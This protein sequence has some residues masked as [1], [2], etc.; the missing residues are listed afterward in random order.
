MSRSFPIAGCRRHS[1]TD[2][3]SR[4]ERRSR[5]DSMASW[6]S[7]FERTGVRSLVS[8]YQPWLFL[9]GPH[10]HRRR[11]LGAGDAVAERVHQPILQI[12]N[13]LGGL[14]LRRPLVTGERN[15]ADAF[16]PNP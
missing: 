4:L 13:L 6:T 1:A 15:E 11:R 2:P 9:S 3:D 5:P 16:G 8:V 7:R 12:D 10:R 14:G